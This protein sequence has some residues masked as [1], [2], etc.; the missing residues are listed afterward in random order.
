MA[1]IPE[2]YTVPQAA[3]AL[4]VSTKTI[5]AEIKAGRLPVRRIGLRQRGIRI[6]SDAIKAWAKGVAA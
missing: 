3:Q 6:S 5:Y 4:K 1:S 2:F